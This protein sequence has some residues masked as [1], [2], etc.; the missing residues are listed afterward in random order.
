MKPVLWAN[1]LNLGL[2]C[3]SIQIDKCVTLHVVYESVSLK[4][5]RS[6]CT[7]SWCLMLPVVPSV[8]L[9]AFSLFYVP[10]VT[11]PPCLFVSLSLCLLTPYIFLLITLPCFHSITVFSLCLSLFPTQHLSCFPISYHMFLFLSVPPSFLRISNPPLT[12]SHL[13]P[14]LPFLLPCLPS[15][16]SFS[17]STPCSL[18]VYFWSLSSSPHASI[19]SPWFSL[20]V[21]LSSSLPLSCLCLCSDTFY[22]RTCPTHMRPHRHT[23]HLHIQTQMP[24]FKW[25]F[26][27]S[28][29]NY[30]SGNM[31]YMLN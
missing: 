28:P 5:G 22:S 20:F 25:H 3:L 26:I 6:M 27:L 23:V 7:G 12:L 18:H 30:V 17:D 1:R 8:I 29:I 21:S 11:Q 19:T 31:R 13:S 15:L 24:V 4:Q 16:L 10:C 9:Y 14:S 2:V